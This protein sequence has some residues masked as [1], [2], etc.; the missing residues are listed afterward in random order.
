MTTK[1]TEL[2]ALRER[3][4]EV[5]REKEELAIEHSKQIADM[6]TRFRAVNIHR[7]IEQTGQ[8]IFEMADKLEAAEEANK[9][10]RAE[11]IEEC[12]KVAYNFPHYVN[13]DF[14]QRDEEGLMLPGSPYDRGR[15]DA[16][17]AIRSLADALT[18]KQG[19]TR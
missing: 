1:D 10:L 14:S 11:T 7:V 13:G 8:D 2:E 5:E 12:A 19:E 4:A 3:L 9:R 15:Y 6:A 16:R 17:K 18:G